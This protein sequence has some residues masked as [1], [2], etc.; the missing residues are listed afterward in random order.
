[1][2]ADVTTL[3]RSSITTQR[4]AWMTQLKELQQQISTKTEELGRLQSGAVGLDGAIQ[5]ANVFLEKLGPEE[6]KTGPVAVPAP[7]AK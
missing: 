1:M 3:D 5:G 2:S 6:S 7:D 4:D